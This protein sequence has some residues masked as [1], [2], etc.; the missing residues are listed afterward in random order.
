MQKLALVMHSKDNVATAIADIP[1]HTKV[2]IDNDGALR[3]IETVQPIP[4]G[5]KFALND[6]VSG[7]IIMKYGEIIGVASK[8][9]KVG[10]HVHTHN[11]ESRRGRGDL[12][13]EK[14]G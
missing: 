7:D 11:V 1:G 9:I 10:E 13:V 4:F 3:E 5:H 8:A 6:I 14:R 12:T 2:A